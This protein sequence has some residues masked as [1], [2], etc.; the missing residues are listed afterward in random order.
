MS[1][2]EYY[3]NKPE[4]QFDGSWLSALQGAISGGFKKNKRGCTR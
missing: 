2:P 1:N 4:P 3:I